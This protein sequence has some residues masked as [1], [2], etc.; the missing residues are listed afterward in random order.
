MDIEID[1]M[2]SSVEQ[3]NSL[4]TFCMV[5][6]MSGVLGMP[7]VMKMYLFKVKYSFRLSPN[8]I[9]VS[10][11]LLSLSEA[12]SRPEI[13]FLK[14][15]CGTAPYSTRLVNEGAFPISEVPTLLLWDS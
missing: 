6:V 10:V 9:S 13:V 12:P 1:I 7:R 11:S 4:L 3:C 14:L 5:S 15:D 8:T 2:L